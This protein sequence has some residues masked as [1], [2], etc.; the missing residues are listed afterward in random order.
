MTKM[1]SK[2]LKLY[3]LVMEGLETKRKPI[4]KVDQ[5]SPKEFL[6]FLKELLPYIKDGKVDLNDVRITEKVDGNA[7][8][9]LTVNGQMRFESSYSGVVTYSKYPNKEAGKFLWQNYSQLFQDIHDLI[10][11]DFKIIGELI[12]IGPGNTAEKVTP[13]G[14]SYLTEKFG[15]NGGIV[16][17]DILKIEGDE[18]VPFEKEKEEEIFNMIRDLNNEDFSFYLSEAIDLTKDV[19]FELDVEQLQKLVNDPEFNKERFDRKADAKIIEEIKKMK[20][21]VCEQLS[22]TIDNTKGAFSA[23]GDLIEGIVV[24]INSS[25]NQY[26]MFSNGY[27]DMKMKY[28]SKFEEYEKTI[29]EFYKSVF[30]YGKNMFKI[31]MKKGAITLDDSYREKYEQA[32][33]DYL[34]KLL[35]M[36][37]DIKD[38][39]KIPANVKDMNINMGRRDYM[40]IRKPF[41]EFVA[42]FNNK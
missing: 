22:K 20:A 4:M 6:R 13:V 15:A 31:Q 38:D 28:W 24:R 29:D 5:M 41:D 10:G 11:S 34:P 19:T 16:V 23:Q 40:E 18:L 8:R 12:W 36:A 32:Q 7:I 21:N 33:Q 25:G 35:Q 1:K 27:K 30:G 39:E 14:A 26:G 2:F 3:N 9:L 42:K 37:Q 17:F